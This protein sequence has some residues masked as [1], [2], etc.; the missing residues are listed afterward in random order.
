MQ[1]SKKLEFVNEID[2]TNEPSYDQIMSYLDKSCKLINHYSQENFDLKEE[3]K[4]HKDIRKIME[5][6]YIDLQSKMKDLQSK[7]FILNENTNLNTEKNKSIINLLKN[8]GNAT[9]EDY[10]NKSMEKYKQFKHSELECWNRL[11]NIQK[12]S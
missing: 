12:T 1:N 2:D 6:D 9:T 7:Y 10:K 11:K 4:V 8:I 5:T 3:I